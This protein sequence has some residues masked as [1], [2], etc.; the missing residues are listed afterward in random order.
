MSSSE[1]Y[2]NVEL[3]TLAIYLLGGSANA[4]DVEDVAVE[5]YKLAPQRFSW[6]KYTDQIDIKI[7][8]YSI[9]GACKEKPGYVNG[10]AK[11]G[12]ML[13]KAGLSWA[14]QNANQTEEGKKPRKFSMVDLLEKEKYRLSKSQAYIKFVNGKVKE[15]NN[16]DFRE[17][18]RVNDYFPK[19]VREEKYAKIENAV[20]DDEKL[21]ATWEFL[22]DKFPEE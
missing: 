8:Q 19:N 20:R 12:Y 14:E 1:S 9:Q 17:F 16:V 21:R 13:T 6:K 2:T 22:K 18:T 5:A 3:V 11:F 4:I 10:G 7:V 15:I